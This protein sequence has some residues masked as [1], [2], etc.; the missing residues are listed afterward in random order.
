MPSLSLRQ[1]HPWRSFPAQLCVCRGRDMC[2]VSHLFPYSHVQSPSLPALPSFDRW[3][4][5]IVKYPYSPRRAPCTILSPQHRVLAVEMPYL[6]SSNS[7]RHR[8]GSMGCPRLASTR[9]VQRRRKLNRARGGTEGSI[10]G[11]GRART[12]ARNSG[13]QRRAGR[14]EPRGTGQGRGPRGQAPT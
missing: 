14:E 5:L 7:T 10:P 3:L 1:L 12:P 2:H 9:K 4:L 8:S 6:H 11:K 13:S